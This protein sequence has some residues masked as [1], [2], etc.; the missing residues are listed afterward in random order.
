MP[1]QAMR[2]RA[3]VAALGIAAL[4]LLDILVI[5]ATEPRLDREPFLS[6]D[7]SRESTLVTLYG[8]LLSISLVAWFLLRRKY[9]TGSRGARVLVFAAVALLG[10]RGVLATAGSRAAFD[11]ARAARTVAKLRVVDQRLQEF[12]HANGRLPVAL[13][14]LGL[15]TQE[16]T[17]EWR[18]TIRYAPQPERRSYRL[19]SEGAPPGKPGLEDFYG[20][21]SINHSP[22]DPVTLAPR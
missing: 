17:D 21:L 1:I 6:L 5:R 10:A 8:A 16:L 20:R 4:S 11:R 22:E 3:W 14:E 7:L 19:W 15:S 2:T 9:L 18:R 13:T 12:S